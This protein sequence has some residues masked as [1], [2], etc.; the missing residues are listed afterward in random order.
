[1]HVLSYGALSEELISLLNLIGFPAFALQTNTYAYTCISPFILSF[2]KALFSE[3]F[4]R[5]SGI[6]IVF[7]SIYL[8]QMLPQTLLLQ[9]ECATSVYF[10]IDYAVFVQIRTHTTVNW[11]TTAGCDW[12]EL[13]FRSSIMSSPTYRLR[14]RSAEYS[15]LGWPDNLS[16][17]STVLIRF[18]FFF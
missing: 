18:F 5:Q 1:M 17:S 14:I 7:A 9:H 10:G 8:S 6:E 12:I 2:I 4:I 16:S 11:Q 3:W 13:N 15:F